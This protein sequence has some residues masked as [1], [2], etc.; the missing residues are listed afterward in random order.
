MKTLYLVRH[1]K[2]SWKNEDLNDIERP[3]KKRGIR[4]AEFMAKLLKKSN[5]IPE[6][7]TSSPAVRAFD[8]ARI[9]SEK[10][11]IDK[12]NILKIDKLYMA[13]YDDFISV[14]KE[15]PENIN[16]AMLFSH[17]PGLTY[18]VCAVSGANID[19]I[20]TCGIVRLDF[21][22]NN[23]NAINTMKGKLIFFEFPKKYE[24]PEDKD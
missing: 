12:N 2:S 22:I 16:K 7:I 13:D 11:E 5:N 21:E 6:L 23:W 10:F 24:E 18:F 3:L 8:T 17:N 9:F 14:I 4:N 1:A 20:T 15:F 19:N